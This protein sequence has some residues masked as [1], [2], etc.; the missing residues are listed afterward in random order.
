VNEKRYSPPDRDD[1]NLG[2][3]NS[4]LTKLSSIFAK[5]VDVITYEYDFGDGWEIELR[6]GTTP[7][8]FKQTQ[9]AECIEG[10]RHG[11]VEDSGGSRRYMEKVAIFR[12]PQHRR[13]QEIRTW[14]GHD[15]DPEAFSLTATN[16]ML[17]EIG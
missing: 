5:N 9:S 17:K 7:G 16:E 3:S 8:P 12:N 2:K 11:P 4:I 1:G 14:M 6:N 15:F 13:Y 10:L